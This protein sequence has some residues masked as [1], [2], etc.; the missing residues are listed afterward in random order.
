MRR[1]LQLGDYLLINNIGPQMNL[2]PK[3][4]N[5][6]ANYVP[7]GRVRKVRLKTAAEDICREL[8]SLCLLEEVN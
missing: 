4:I 5:K 1:D 3:A 7:G 2:W 8:R 6:Q